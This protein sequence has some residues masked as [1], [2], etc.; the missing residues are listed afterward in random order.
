MSVPGVGVITALTFRHTI[1]DPSR[2]HSANDVGAYLGLTPRRKQSGETD[3]N[4]RRWRG[5]SE[6]RRA[7]LARHLMAASESPPRTA[8][9]CGGRC[10][11]AVDFLSIELHHLTATPLGIGP[12]RGPCPP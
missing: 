8:K 6:A 4:L 12:I 9:G 3:V 5:A 7:R 2:F 11:F 10:H 1:D